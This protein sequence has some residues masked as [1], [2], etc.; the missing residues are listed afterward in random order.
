M[1]EKKSQK[2][3]YRNQKNKLFAE[4]INDRAPQWFVLVLVFVTERLRNFEI[5]DIWL[6]AEKWQ[7]G[8]IYQPHAGEQLHDIHP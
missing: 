7:L 2:R 6:D 5:I 3:W 1:K 8:V 4:V